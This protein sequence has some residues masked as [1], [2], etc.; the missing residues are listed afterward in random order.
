MTNKSNYIL[1]KQ[2]FH[3]ISSEEQSLGYDTTNYDVVPFGDVVL[4][5]EIIFTTKSEME[6]LV[7]KL[8]DTM[9]KKKYKNIISYKPVKYSFCALSRRI[10][11]LEE[12]LKK[13]FIEEQK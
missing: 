3:G 8:N 10:L 7:K 2:K 9:P 4:E 6:I 5:K 13:Y 1:I 11:S 12:I